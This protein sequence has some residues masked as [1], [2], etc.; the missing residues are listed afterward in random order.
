MW[1]IHLFVA[2]TAREIRNEAREEIVKKEIVNNSQLEIQVL[3]QHLIKSENKFNAPAV[4]AANKDRSLHQVGTVTKQGKQADWFKK[5]NQNVYYNGENRGFQD[6]AKNYA[7]IEDLQKREVIAAEFLRFFIPET[8]KYRI[9]DGKV[10][11]ISKKVGLNRADGNY[12]GEIK[13]LAEHKP[14]IEDVLQQNK[15]LAK[16]FYKIQIAS[17][18]IGSYDS[19]LN[20]I[21]YSKDKNGKETLYPIDFGASCLDMKTFLDGE[22]GQKAENTIYRILNHKDANP[23]AFKEAIY[24]V[25]KVWNEKEGEIKEHIRKCCKALDVPDAEQNKLFEMINA[26]KQFMSNQ[27]TITHQKRNHQITSTLEPIIIIG[28]HQIAEYENRQ[29]NLEQGAE[30]GFVI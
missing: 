4:A 26:N 29:N 19:H 2:K 9:I 20:N 6:P 30:P 15:E 12:A 27:Q 8:P 11:V 23:E 14:G 16:E 7:V 10:E 18:L 21:M 13:A 5:D 3:R 1:L 17:A 22:F 24:E 28:E 25:S